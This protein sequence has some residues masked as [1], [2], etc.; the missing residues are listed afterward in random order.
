MSGH[1]R[2]HHCHLKAIPSRWERGKGE[3]DQ[4]ICPFSLNVL[5]NYI[6]SNILQKIISTCSTIADPG[7]SEYCKLKSWCCHSCSGPLSA[8]SV[9][10]GCP[11]KPIH[12]RGNAQFWKFQEA[13]AREQFLESKLLSLQRLIGDTEMASSQGWRALMDEDRLLTRCTI[14]FNKAVLGLMLIYIGLRFWKAS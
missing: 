6:G 7:K 14:S 13:L 10:T 5:P 2:L 11:R 1:S 12:K 4:Q 9:Y 8:E 3:Q